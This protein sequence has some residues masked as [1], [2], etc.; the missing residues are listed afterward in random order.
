M[1]HAGKIAAKAKKEDSSRVYGKIRRV[2]NNENHRHGIKIIDDIKAELSETAQDKLK[3]MIVDTVEK[4]FQK[5][6][7]KITRKLTINFIVSGVALAGF[8]LIVNNADKIA[9]LIVK[10]KK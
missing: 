6:V 5:E 3:A 8:V 4:K 9:D 1:T 10:P 2:R 7:K